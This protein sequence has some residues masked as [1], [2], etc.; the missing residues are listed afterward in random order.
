VSSTFIGSFSSG[1]LLPQPAT[2]HVA[3]NIPV[4]TAIRIAAPP[5]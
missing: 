1:S 2:S 4:A 5:N 3:A